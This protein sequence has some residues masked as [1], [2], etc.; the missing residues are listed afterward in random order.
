MDAIAL[1]FLAL[2]NSPPL[3]D[4]FQWFVDQIPA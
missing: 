2:L 1:L 4:L 3:A